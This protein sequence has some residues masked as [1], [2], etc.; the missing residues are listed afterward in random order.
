M[1][2]SIVIVVVVVVVVVFVV[3]GVISEKIYFKER[4]EFKFAKKK[5]DYL[6]VFLLVLLFL[7]P[8]SSC[9]LGRLSFE[10]RC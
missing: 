10:A 1:A 2:K 5:I 4:C 8:F 7:S 6:P 9:A 3:F